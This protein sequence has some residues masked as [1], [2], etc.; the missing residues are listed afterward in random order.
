MSYEGVIGGRYRLGKKV[1]SG[2]FGEIYSGKEDSD[3]LVATCIDNG[4][5]VA[6]KLVSGLCNPAGTSKDEV[7]AAVV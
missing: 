5:D 4:E 2:S 6:V 1:G 7:P 3:T